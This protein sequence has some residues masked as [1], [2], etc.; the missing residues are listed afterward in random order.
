MMNGGENVLTA[1]QT[2]SAMAGGG[3]PSGIGGGHTYNVTVNGANMTPD[4]LVDA[5][6]RYE[7]RNGP[8]WRA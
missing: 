1:S 4:Q 6:K 3:S 8:G 5:I 2:A 7:R